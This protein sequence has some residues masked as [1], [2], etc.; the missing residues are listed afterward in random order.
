MSKDSRAMRA[1]IRGRNARRKG[2]R[3]KCKA[4]G[5]VRYRDRISA[6]TVLAATQRSRSSSR[7]EQRAYRCDEC[8]GWHLTK[9]RTWRRRKNDSRKERNHVQTA[10]ES[11][12]NKGDAQRGADPRSDERP[13]GGVGDSGSGAEIGR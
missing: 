3:R 9:M 2:K 7:E 5:K 6:L 10:M 4:T 8:G 13:G 11:R 12:K 1:T